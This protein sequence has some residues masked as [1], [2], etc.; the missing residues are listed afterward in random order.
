MKKLFLLVAMF[1]M[2][3]FVSAQCSKTAGAEKKACCAKTKAA[4]AKMAGLD[5]SIE[6]EVCAKSGLVKYYQTAT[7]EKS[8][9]EMRTE[10]KYCDKSQKF[11]NVSPSAASA[12]KDCSKKCEK[13]CTKA[14]EA[15]ATGVS[16]TGK[17]CS[18][19]DGKKC[20]KKGKSVKADAGAAAAKFTSAKE[21]N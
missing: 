16:N 15:K 2:V 7:C 10:V 5:N 3:G 9:K 14:T 18:K 20:C 1:G 6:K 19:K 8:G 13:K 21:E 17:A 12:K 4:A 11:V